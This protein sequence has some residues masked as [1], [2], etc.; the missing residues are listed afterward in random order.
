MFRLPGRATGNCW[1][2]AV[3]LMVWI[4][5]SAVVAGAAESGCPQHF[6]SG[7]APDLIKKE[8]VRK[9]RELCYGVFA[10]L[11]SAETKTPMYVAQLLTRSQLEKSAHVPRKTRFHPEPRLADDERAELQDYAGSGYD[12][13][14]MAPAADMPDEQSQ[15][16][17]FSLAN[18]VPQNPG[19]NRGAWAQLEKAVRNLTQDHGR[20]YV[21]TGPIFVHK[22]EQAGGAVGVPAYLFKAVLISDAGDIK[23]YFVENKERAQVTEIP[24]ESLEEMVGLRL[25]PQRNK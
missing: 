4:L 19:N 13:G 22:P 10:V 20:L 9:L 7:E 11:H 24:V 1:H 8:R 6:A 14:H 2:L 21:I 12:R 17:S 5:L 18:M 23:A 3:N 16:E 15:Y 25:F